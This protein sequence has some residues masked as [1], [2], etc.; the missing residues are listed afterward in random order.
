MGLQ[1]ALWLRDCY[2]FLLENTYIAYDEAQRWRLISVALAV[3]TWDMYKRP[4]IILF[5][6]QHH[7]D[8]LK[9]VIV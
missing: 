3:L 4:R 8:C 6:E 7:K 5:C 2:F 9:K 1:D